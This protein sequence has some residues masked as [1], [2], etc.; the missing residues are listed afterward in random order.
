LILTQTLQA[1]HGPG[2]R[3][4][5]PNQAVAIKGVILKCFECSNGSRGHGWLQVQV[6][7]VIWGVTL[8]D[9]P[10]LRKAK[11][12][13]SKL[14]KGLAIE[15]SGFANVS[16]PHNMYANEITVNG[17]KLFRPAI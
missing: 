7:S 10:G 6:D 3:G 11:I 5:N 17:V 1:H 2:I 9:T 16:K 12:S 15:V 8:P 14:K 13:L 4:Y